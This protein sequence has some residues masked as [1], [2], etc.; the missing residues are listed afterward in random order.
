MTAPPGQDCPAPPVTVGRGNR[1]EEQRILT[2]TPFSPPEDEK[3]LALDGKTR[4]KPAKTKQPKLDPLEGIEFPEGFDLADVRQALCDYLTH[5][6][7]AY[8]NPARSL[9]LMLKNFAGF[10]PQ[11]FIDAVE[12]TE[13]NG[14]TGVFTPKGNNHEQTRKHL[15]RDGGPIR[16]APGRVYDD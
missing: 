15:G 14:W 6:K 7:A 4:G 3:S 16:R 1:E 8:K 12:L 9:S 10:T 2:D 5:R 11:D 13:A